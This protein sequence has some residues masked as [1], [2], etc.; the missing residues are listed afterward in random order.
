MMIFVIITMRRRRRRTRKRRRKRRGRRRRR[1]IIV[2]IIIIIIIFVTV[3]TQFVRGDKV[4]E[5]DEIAKGE[6]FHYQSINCLYV[7]FNSLY[8][9]KG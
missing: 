7:F 4:K 8:A 1:F 5:M 2:I 6:S 3:G 9:A